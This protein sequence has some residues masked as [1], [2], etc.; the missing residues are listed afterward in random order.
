MPVPCGGRLRLGVSRDD[1]HALTEPGRWVATHRRRPW[2]PVFAAAVKTF[3]LRTGRASC[4][5]LSPDRLDTM[6]FRDAT[7]YGAGMRLMWKSVIVAFGFVAVALGTSVPASAAPV[8]DPCS[9]GVTMLCRFLPIAP[10]LDHDIDL[11]KD[12]GAV[13]GEVLPQMPQPSQDAQE[14]G[15]FPVCDNGCT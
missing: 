8:D 10:G 12:A 1:G 13:D 15:S 11:T 4:D 2:V 9:L 14:P 6:T 7:G 3:G 5:L